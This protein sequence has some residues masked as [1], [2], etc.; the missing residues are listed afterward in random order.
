MKNKAGWICFLGALFVASSAL[1]GQGAGQPRI[2]KVSGDGQ[3]VQYLWSFTQPL[4]VR[5]VDGSGQPIAGRQVAWSDLGGISYAS[6]KVTTTDANGFALL[7]WIPGGD[8]G[9]GVP[10]LSYTI[11]ATTD[12][13]SVSFSAVAYPFQSGSFNPQPSVQFQKPG[14]G[15]APIE[16]RVGD[17]LVDAVRVAVVTT[18]GPGVSPG[19]PIPGVG[20]TVTS[21]NQNPGQGPV[22]VCEGGTPLTNANGIASCDLLVSGTV[23][24][25]QLVVN[26][27]D[28]V[29]QPAQLTVLPGTSSSVV[30][31][32]GNNQSGVPG[33][34]LPL[35]LVARIVN[36]S[37]QALAGVAATWT[38]VTPGSLALVNPVA[39]SDA[40]GLVS[41][42]VQLGTTPGSYQVRVTA[43]AG[44]A[45][46]NVTVQSGVPAQ[47][48]ITTASLPNGAVGTIYNRSLAL[49][50]GTP[51]YTWSLAAGTLPPGLTL[52]PAGVI[53]GTPQSVGAYNITVRVTDGAGAVAT[54][55]LS[56][57][58]GSGVIITTTSLPTAAPGV[59]YAHQ[60]LATGGTPPYEWRHDPGTFAVRPLPP[61]LQLTLAG[62]LTGTPT[63]AGT[64]PFTVVVRDA[65]GV[66]ASQT[67]TLVVQLG[68]GGGGGV[69]GTPL[70][71]TTTSLPPATSQGAY[72]QTLAASGGTPPYNWSVAVGTLPQGVTLTASGVLSGIPIIPGSYGFTVQVTDGLGTVA[73]R[74]LNL[75][76]TA[77]ASLTITTPAT[78]PNGVVTISYLQQLAA[79]G[80]QAPYSWTLMSGALPAGI[81]ISTSG[82]LSGTPQVAATSVFTMTVRDA[83]G[84]TASRQFTLVIGTGITV[85]S[86]ASLPAGAVGLAYNYTLAATGGTGQY[87]WTLFSG[88]LPQGLSLT[89]QGAIIGTPAVA[90]VGAFVVRVSDSS[91]LFRLA[92]FSI[93][94]TADVVLPRAGVV[95]QLAAG[96]GWNTGLSLVNAGTAG[97]RVQ[98]QFRGQTGEPLALPVTVTQAGTGVTQVLDLVEVTVPANGTVVI[99]TID[100]S[101]ATTVGWAEVRSSSPV[102]GFA[103]FRQTSG[104]GRVSE[105]TSPVEE[106]APQQVLAPYDNTGG[107]VTGVAVVNLSAAEATVTVVQRGDSGQELGTDTW[108]LPGRGHTSFAV[109]V[110]YP[111]LAGRRGTLEFR[112]NRP[113]GV[114]GLGL[115]FSPALTFTSIPVVARP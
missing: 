109:P 99:D 95:A 97:A 46:F 83:A 26:V 43:G 68:G 56:L 84:T 70:T 1:Y 61:G 77:A 105:G 86:P 75:E 55:A 112:S 52:S 51:P 45:T 89:P 34:T 10:F 94:V 13:G 78:L 36:S 32:Q 11:T 62:V 6:D 88:A 7:Q 35:P 47:L 15:A 92:T 66:V 39:V 50:G 18:G 12:V 67:L 33:Q 65:A 102:S 2:L 74:N 53:T 91:G 93:E 81:L 40:A 90:S 110:Q 63:Q 20:L 44:E 42:N 87:S 104:D 64:W 31:V 41:A 59:P 106:R 14:Q 80:G 23:G 71:V 9:I 111:G 69:G 16:G 25:T 60:L 101:A 79:T 57:A 72:A 19:L 49:A 5:V 103:I 98:V 37:G 27:G 82:L 115:R 22:A 28:M 114:M 108:T 85:T 3:L 58:I 100:T 30:I 96:G 21:V 76:V 24:T 48:T 8:F 73:I 107:F 4:V 29:T 54:R 17:R 38:V 113:E